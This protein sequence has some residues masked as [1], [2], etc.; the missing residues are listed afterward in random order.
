[1]QNK[2]DLKKKL[3]PI[4]YEVTQHSATEPPFHNEYWDNDKDGIYVDVVSGEPLFSSLDKYDAG[5]GWPSFTKPLDKDRI[6]E[7]QDYTH[8]M[9]RTEVRSENSDSHLGHVFPDGPVQTGGLRY[10]INSA[11][12]RFVPKEDLER[13]GYGEYLKLFG[14]QK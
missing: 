4:Q 14:D 12:L 9:I 8:G 2:E 13:E 3:T 7:K 1:M 5:C 6:L 11:A 10:C